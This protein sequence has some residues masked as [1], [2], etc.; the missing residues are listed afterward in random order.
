MYKSTEKERQLF[1]N[2]LAAEIAFQFVGLRLKSSHTA[3]F[4]ETIMQNS[5]LKR[6]RRGSVDAEKM[7]EG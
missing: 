2:D 7:S 1:K 4:F 3:E 5:H 6:R